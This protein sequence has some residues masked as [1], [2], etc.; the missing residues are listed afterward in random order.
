MHQ[1]TIASKQWKIV[2]IMLIIAYLMQYMIQHFINHKMDHDVEW[3]N[4]GYQISLRNM[5]IEKAFELVFWFSYQCYNVWTK[6]DILQ[7]VSKIEIVW[8]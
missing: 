3:F 7:L 1:G 6:P 2:A 5:V 4:S 8:V